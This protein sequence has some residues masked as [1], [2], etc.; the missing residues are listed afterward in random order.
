MKTTGAKLKMAK[1]HERALILAIETL[2]LYADPSSYHAVYFA[3]DQPCGWFASDR[4]KVDRGLFR[5]RMHGAAARRA[6]KRI[7]KIVAVNR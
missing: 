2:A 6:L 7:E 5:R 3:Y 4:S 1:R